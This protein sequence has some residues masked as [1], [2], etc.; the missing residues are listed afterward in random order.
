MSV[1]YEITVTGK[2]SA[3][4]AFVAAC[5]AGVGGREMAEF[6]RDL[7]LE[8]S[9]VSQLVRE[10]FA[11]GSRHL[12]FAPAALAHDLELALRG[13]GGEA[14][15]ELDGVREVV[16]AKVRF[17]ASAFSRELAGRIRTDLLQALPPGV[18]GREIEEHEDCDPDAR[19]A[20]LYTP[21]HEY[22]Y[23]A[24]G[25]FSGPFPG[26]VEVHRRAADL[27]FVK[28]GPIELETRPAGPEERANG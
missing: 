28:L 23:R 16:S 21:E 6:G 25:V 8:P 19:E 17:K 7:D 12:V 26:I 3:V 10:L 18:E 2:E 24:S 20:E 4:R 11:K 22:V 5:A 13:R 14:D 9:G 1:W 15:L 27:P